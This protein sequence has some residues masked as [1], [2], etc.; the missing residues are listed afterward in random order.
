LRRAGEERGQAMAEFALIIPI[1]LVVVV[2]ILEFGRVLFYWIEANHQANEAAR[3]AAVDRNPYSPT[4]LQQ[5]ARSGTTLEFSDASVCI[6]YPLSTSDI[7]DPV[8]VRVQKP[9]NVVP[10]IG[11]G[12]I[13]IKGAATMRIERIGPTPTYGVTTPPNLGTCT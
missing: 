5:H 13:V 1:L 4:T 2:G 9:F 6:D 11:V 12:T 7:G 8:R 10:F 3:W